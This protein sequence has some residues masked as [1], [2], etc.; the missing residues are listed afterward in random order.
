MSIVG[1]AVAAI[2]A[3]APAQAEHA[4]AMHGEPA[5]PPGFVS[6]PH[7]NPDAPQG[8]VLRLA[9]TGGFDNLNPFIVRGRPAA[10]L[11]FTY[12][13]LLVRNWD[14]PFALYAGLAEDVK[15]DPERV[16]VTFRLNPAARFHDG[17]EV[18][19]HDV[20]FSY[21]TLRRW[22]R[23]NHRTYY[24]QVD[25]A[26]VV[27]QRSVR[28]TLQPGN[29]EL[30]LLLALMPVFS[31]ADFE[32]RRFDRVTLDPLLTSGPY[33][34]AEVDAGRSITYR[35]QRPHWTDDVPAYR[36]RHNFD[37]LRFD[38]Y[39]D[40]DAALTAFLAGA[41]DVRLE[42]D[43]QRWAKAYDT[44]AARAG[45]IRLQQFANRSPAG[46][47]GL[48]LNLRRPPFDDSRVRRAVAHGFD[49]AWL[50]R[51]LFFGAYE[52]TASYFAG[53][54]LAAPWPP[55]EA[56]LALLQ[57]YRTTLPDELFDGAYAPP[58]AGDQQAMRA[59]LRAAQKLLRA[60][61]WQVKDGAATRDGQTLGFEIMATD[62]LQ[63]KLA[64]HLKR[65]LARLGIAIDVR[66]VDS[67]Q[68]AERRARFDFDAVFHD[69]GA[70]LSP[71]TEQ[72]F[73]WSSAAAGQDGSRNYP[74][75]RSRVVDAMIARLVS[76][77]T[78]EELVAACHALDRVLQW[79]NYV[80]PLF[81]QPG[82]R[83]AIWNGLAWPAYT[84]AYGYQIDTWWRE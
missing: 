82:D 31:A 83:L 78:R 52:R 81:H 80:V 61:G 36:G 9:H 58:D 76:A 51:T 34:V 4:I 65:N 38:Y 14:E 12:Q 16:S 26:K 32:T 84:A 8:G 49:F 72:A 5:L 55:S 43:P 40:G 46:M 10:G 22:G 13:S 66:L 50:N 41:Y 19:V 20:L 33:K 44:P 70:S 29:R 39:R 79:G 53:S 62:R 60:A 54:E 1:L 57:P 37:E 45:D 35:R 47:F 2:L 21:R 17:S 71:G 68:Y 64:L 6:F 28:F 27:G 63:E 74:G 18:T 69:W 77:R 11:G 24:G 23:P 56:E 30:P 67:A 25:E 3:A 42:T 15:T 73:Y 48:A 75:I 59:N 7:A